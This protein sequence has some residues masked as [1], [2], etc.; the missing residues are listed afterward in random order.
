[1]RGSED[2]VRATNSDLV[3]L[4]RMGAVPFDASEPAS[5][6]QRSHRVDPYKGAR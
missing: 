2:Q 5:I 1:M 4:V 3:P 6:N